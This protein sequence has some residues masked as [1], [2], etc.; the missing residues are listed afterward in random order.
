MDGYLAC[1]VALDMRY[2]F[3]SFFYFSVEWYFC[4]GGLNINKKNFKSSPICT[5]SLRTND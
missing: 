5:T 4:G 3:Y 1:V 2:A